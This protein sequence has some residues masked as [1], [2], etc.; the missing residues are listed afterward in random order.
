MTTRKTF[1]SLLPTFPPLTNINMKRRKI[2]TVLLV[3]FALVLVVL[4]AGSCYMVDFALSNA[5]RDRSTNAGY[6][7]VMRTYPELR[8][9][10][11]SLRHEGAV[12]DTLI[13]LP[14][15]ERQYALYIRSRTAHG[16]TA[17]LVH[18]YKNRLVHMLP[19]ARIY[20][21]VLGYN[22]L[23]PDLH[24][25]GCS[26][27]DDIRMGWKDRLDVMRWIDLAP[28][29]FCSATDTARIVVHGVSMGAATTMCVSGE[30]T[31]DAV[32]C[33]V[34]DCGYT[35]VWDEFQG[36]LRNQFSLPAFPLLYTS[37]ALCRIR[38]GWTFG[39]ASPL[40]Q[41]AKCEKPMLFIHGSADTFVPTAMVHP[42]YAA[43]PEPK[44]LWI[45]P[46]SAHAH[47]YKD[48]RDEYTARV[49]QF[50]QEYI[51]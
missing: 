20:N 38:Y 8:P 1:F 45:A 28:Q 16:R 33:F 9:W 44:A 29:M 49:T 19:Y 46:G 13:T 30:K 51:R 42:L 11:D 14:D 5:D 7:S 48:H 24:G 12:S 18:G 3:F 47:S 2:L 36:E 25:H 6:A 34:E 37:D 39:E 21:K 35:S 32:R 41:V 23:L 4:A 10:L 31:S 22:I 17:V 50:V 40:R 27:G 15:G 26:D 43:K